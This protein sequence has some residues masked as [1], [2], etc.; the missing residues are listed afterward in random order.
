M[1]GV[2]QYLFFKNQGKD[3]LYRDLDPVYAELVG[4]GCGG[5][6]RIKN[7]FAQL[8][9]IIKPVEFEFINFQ[10]QLTIGL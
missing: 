3:L 5:I 10:L 1:Y 2:D 4:S 8:H 7:T 6:G 9:F